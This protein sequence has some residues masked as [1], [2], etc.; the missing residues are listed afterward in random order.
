MLIEPPLAGTAGRKQFLIYILQFGTTSIPA[1]A[2]VIFLASNSQCGQIHVF[3]PP[4]LVLPANPL[5]YHCMVPIL[6]KIA[7]PR[8]HTSMTFFG[9]PLKISMCAIA[10]FGNSHEHVCETNEIIYHKHILKKHYNMYLSGL[11]LTLAFWAFRVQNSTSQGSHI[12]QVGPVP[13]EASSLCPSAK[14]HWSNGV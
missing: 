7:V 8:W 6:I 2:N 5:A 9:L 14:V 13:P 11:V 3:V 12:F 10:V 1:L 4:G